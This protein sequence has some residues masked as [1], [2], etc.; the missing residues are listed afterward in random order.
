MKNLSLNVTSC[1]GLLILF[2]FT[3]EV[4]Q[5]RGFGWSTLQMKRESI[6]LLNNV[7]FICSLGRNSPL[8][9]TWEGWKEKC[10]LAVAIFWHVGTAIH[11]VG[12]VRPPLIPQLG[13]RW[14][15]RDRLV[16][17]PSSF[18]NAWYQP[19]YWIFSNIKT[20]VLPQEA[21]YKVGRLVPEAILYRMELWKGTASIAC[22]CLW[23]SLVLKNPAWQNRNS[24]I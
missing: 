17:V 4:L 5:S 7:Q 13:S 22:G 9:K 19:V 21:T 8:Q 18:I 6:N 20:A 1:P 3:I 15:W 11:A 24:R 16:L 2:C 12:V 10:Y 14:G 23:L